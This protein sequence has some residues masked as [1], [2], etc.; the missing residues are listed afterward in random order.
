MLAHHREQTI[1]MWMP[2]TG[3]GVWRKLLSRYPEWV[4]HVA[5]RVKPEPKRETVTLYCGFRWI[6][7]TIRVEDVEG[8]KEEFVITFDTLDGEPD[9][10][11]IRME[12][13]ED[14]E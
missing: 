6:A 7:T 12:K 1:E 4:G 8:Y 2:E 13:L 14:E 10:S 3:D 11:T 5:Y 9:C